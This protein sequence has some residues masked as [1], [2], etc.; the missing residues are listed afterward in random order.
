MDAAELPALETAETGV[1]TEHVAEQ[2]DRTETRADIVVQ[3]RCDPQAQA[4]YGQQMPDP[5]AVCQSERAE[6]QADHGEAE[7]PGFPDQRSDP[8]RDRR[9]GLSPRSNPAGALHPEGIAARPEFRVRRVIPSPARN[10]GIVI[11]IQAIAIAILF[12]RRVGERRELEGAVLGA[13]R[14]LWLALPVLFPFGGPGFGWEFTASAALGAFAGY[15]GSMVE[16]IGD[17][18][19]TCAVAG[20]TFRVRHMNRGIFAEGLGCVVASAFGGLPCTSYTQNIG[21]I[22]T[23][24]VASRHVVQ[25][26]AVILMLYGLS[27]RFGALLV[28]MPRS[29]LGGVFV[30]VCGMI[31]MSG[32]RLLRTAPATAANSLVVGTTLVAA[33]GIPFYVRSG[34]GEAWLARLPA[35]GRR[36]LTNTVVLGVGLNLALNVW[37]GGRQAD[38]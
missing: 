20:E 23:T 9:A 37:L 28:A 36:L 30:I 4:L 26:A 25:V 29:V 14:D 22:A 15:V 27:P 8:E 32:I 1:S 2:R 5:D 11:S 13:R 31:V 6:N 17:Y 19:A 24:R 18:A 38:P 35:M 34:L 33:L 10:P 16:S 21:I 3:I 7:P 12:R